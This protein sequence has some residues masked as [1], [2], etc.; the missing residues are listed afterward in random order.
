MILPPTPCGLRISLATVFLHLKMPILKSL[1]IVLTMFLGRPLFL[2]MLPTC[3]SG[4]L[5]APWGLWFDAGTSALFVA[6][7]GNQRVLVFDNAGSLQNDAS[8]NSVIGQ[9]DLSTCTGAMDA[10]TMIIP[11]GIYYDTSLNLMVADF[12]H[13]RVL[14]YQC[15]TTTKTPSASKK[16][17]S[18]PSQTGT[19][20]KNPVLLSGVVAPS[21][22]HTKVGGA[23][24]SSTNGGIIARL[25]CQAICN[26]TFQVC[27][28]SG[29][30]TRLCRVQKKS[31]VHD[32]PA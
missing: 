21:A 31:C 23:S 10:N 22:S 17:G 19:G 8:A 9:T 2:T 7:Y 26:G 27:K 30:P 32:C 6:D 1:E 28:R 24:K 4:G 16:A 11:Y 14:R 29:I 13:N 5:S 12:A 3:L 20:T 18:S 25:A 15:P